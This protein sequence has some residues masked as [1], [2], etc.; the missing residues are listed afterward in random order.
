[1]LNNVTERGRYIIIEGADGTGKSTQADMMQSYLRESHGINS[2]Q[3]HEPDG[4]EGSEELDIPAVT[5]ATELRKI[6]KNGTIDRDP[7]TN[8]MLFTAARRLN[9]QQAIKP[10]LDKGVW[11]IGARNYLSTLAY[12]GY[13]EGVDIDRIIEYTRD[14][15]SKEY[16]NPDLSI[17]LTLGNEAVRSSRILSRGELEQPDTFESRSADFQ[18]AMQAGYLTYARDNDLPIINASDTVES[19]QT[20]LNAILKEKFN[21]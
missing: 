3:V 4:F 5:G 12:Q 16:L 7:W 20:Q 14:N 13:G 8:V 11:V 17:I 19:V 21:L 10:A 9:W 2:I 1:M 18:E 6:I 15:V